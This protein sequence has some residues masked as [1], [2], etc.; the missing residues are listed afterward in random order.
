MLTFFTINFLLHFVHKRKQELV[1]HFD[2]SMQHN[3]NNN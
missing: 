1:L 3:F 2:H